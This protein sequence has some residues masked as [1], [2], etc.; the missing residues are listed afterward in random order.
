MGVQF[1]TYFKENV[2]KCLK[3]FYDISTLYKHT[4]ISRLYDGEI[5]AVP[6]STVK[7]LHKHVLGSALTDGTDS[8]LE[9][10]H[11]DPFLR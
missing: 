7:L 1:I 5:N 6:E 2:F 9:K 8:E 11:P 4:V 3:D 10:A